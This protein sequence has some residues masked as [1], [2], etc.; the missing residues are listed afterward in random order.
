MKERNKS[1]DHLRG[2]A[3]LVMLLT[4][5]LAVYLGKGPFINLLWDKSHFAVP[6]FVFC[7]AFL[8]LHKEVDAP[9]HR[10]LP[11]VKK[12]LVRLLKPY[13]IFLFVNI[14]VLLAFKPQILSKEYLLQSITLTGGIDINWLI[15]LF[16]QFIP[17]FLLVRYLLK[18]N[19]TFFYVFGMLCLLSSVA[20]LF[21]TPHLNYKWY[22]WIPWSTLIFFAY[23]FMHA[24]TRRKIIMT[25]SLWAAHSITYFFLLHM[26][27]TTNLFQN[28]YPPN[29]Y[30]LSYGMAITPVLLWLSI[31]GL[32]AFKPLD[33]AITY[34]STFSY[35]FFFIHYIIIEVMA[36][37][38]FQR[39]IPWPI[40]FT[41]VVVLTYLTQFSITK[42]LQAVH[43]TK[44]S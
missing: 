33:R 27:E 21:W 12:R 19:K 18:R 23:L 29:F 3:I 10:I 4:H 41:A 5:S 15:L 28:K 42:G 34:A 26:H 30:Y 16:V 6:V 31:K 38:A 32:F 22:M 14:L 20:L 17:V 25:I 11:Y 1:I 7:S 13:Y 24:D 35:D 40:F 44:K 9:I 36:I 8:F 37:F 39:W 2:I 43:R